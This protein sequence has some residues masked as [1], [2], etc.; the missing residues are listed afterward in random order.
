MSLSGS[1]A[2]K[3]VDVDFFL[4][5]TRSPLRSDLLK[6]GLT[7]EAEADALS[8]EAAEDRRALLIRLLVVSLRCSLKVSDL[9]SPPED[10]WF[11]G[12]WEVEVSENKE[13]RVWLA[14]AVGAVPLRSSW[15]HSI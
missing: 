5:L 8:E 12:S 15:N 13:D 6:I 1:I 4:L 2:P 3:V 7:S 10:D 14:L 9:L 11:V